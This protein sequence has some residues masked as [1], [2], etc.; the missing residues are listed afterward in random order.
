MQNTLKL[1]HLER[2][3]EQ[4]DSLTTTILIA[5]LVLH[6]VLIQALKNSALKEVIVFF[7]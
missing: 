4:E 1:G 2:K 3:I 6:L 5:P 7:W